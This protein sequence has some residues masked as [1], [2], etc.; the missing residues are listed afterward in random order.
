MIKLVRVAITLFACYVMCFTPAS[1]VDFFRSLI[2]LS[3]GYAYDYYSIKNFAVGIGDKYNKVLGWVGAVVALIFF[4][5][6]LAGLSG[7]FVISLD[8][9]PFMVNSSDKVMFRCSFPLEWLLMSLVAFPILAGFEL[10]GTF[11]N[12][13]NNM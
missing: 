13:Q 5:F 3:M 9:E 12:R 8:K 2:I 4:L 1:G 6:G 11:R 10:W 7:G